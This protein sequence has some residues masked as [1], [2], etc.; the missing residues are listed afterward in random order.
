MLLEKPMSLPSLL[1]MIVKPKPY[2]R[3]MDKN[4][5]TKDCWGGYN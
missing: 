5:V 2:T 1:P 3:I 4:A